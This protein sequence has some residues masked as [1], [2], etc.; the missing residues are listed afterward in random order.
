[1]TKTHTRVRSI[2]FHRPSLGEEEVEA[3]A[4]VIRSGM[5]T[6]GPRTIEFERRFA[7]Y[8][9]ARHA[10]AASSGTAALHLALEA[11]GIGPGDEVIVPTTTF[12]ATAQAVIYLGARP[13]LSDIDSV[14][15]NLDPGGILTRITPATRA[16]VP[17]HLGG[18]PCE[19]HEILEIARQKNLRVIEDAAHA[20]PSRYSGTLIGSLSDFTCFS[21]YATKPLATGEGG[22]IT[23]QSY[24]GAARMQL[25][26][27]HGIER[28]DGKQPGTESSWNYSV[29]EAGYK[30]NFTDIQ[31]A[32]GIVQ[33]AKCDAMRDARSRI[34][35]LYSAAFGANDALE[36]PTVRRNCESSWHLYILRLHLDRLS[37]S[38][39][40]FME[41]MSQKG[42]AC[43][44][45]FI[46]LHLHEFYQ[47][48]YG[49]R[50]GDFPRAESEFRRCISLPIYPGLSDEEVEY[51]I[52]AVK[53]TVAELYVP[54]SIAARA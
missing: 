35:E 24:D 40:A 33:L 46:P 36:T 7:E 41:R 54:R 17:V 12:T 31:A 8:V 45:H 5:L 10:V 50:P 53:Q 26:R 32:L 23:T 39:D 2:P 43:S 3:V 13:I 51:V 34:A 48:T 49:Y 20:L 47:R 27:L 38:R 6:M 16:I 19:T 21:F 30:Y 18:N 52:E 1:M 44:V 15:M 37:D 22:M 9:G 14:T 29:R 42:V 25:M 28:P 11:A 4:D